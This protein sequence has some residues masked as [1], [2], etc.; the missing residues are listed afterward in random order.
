MIAKPLVALYAMAWKIAV[1]LHRNIQIKQ[2]HIIPGSV[3]GGVKKQ[4]KIAIE[5]QV[6]PG[7]SRSVRQNV[8]DVAI[9][10]SKESRMAIMV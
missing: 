6:P 4:Y 5:E 3:K 10:S 9:M 1:V 2:R 7:M 8:R